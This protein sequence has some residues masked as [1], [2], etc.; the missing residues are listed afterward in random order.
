MRILIC[1]DSLEDIENLRAML[2]RY[3]GGEP[4]DIT[5]YRSG[6]ELLEKEAKREFSLLFLDI[7]MKE[8]DGIQVAQELRRRGKK[9]AIILISFSNAFGQES[10]EV[11]AAWYLMKPF[12][13]EEFARAVNRG[14]SFVQK[15]VK[16]LKLSQNGGELKVPTDC[17]N[18]IETEG[19]RLVIHMGEEKIKVYD[20][21]ERLYGI[22]GKEAFIRPH[23]SYILNMDFID[24]L[25]EG[26]FRL[27][28]GE[29]VSINRRNRKVIKEIYHKYLFNKLTVS[30]GVKGY[31]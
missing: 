31:G 6:E 2:K 13:Y 30:G 10:Y 18:Y 14:F 28:N 7:Y 29:K 4:E 16:I 3:L 27:R 12:T 5:V 8:V 15:D 26:Q 20:S 9:G 11:E 25:E 24:G 21:L 17:I 23:R 19:R 22:L 1:D